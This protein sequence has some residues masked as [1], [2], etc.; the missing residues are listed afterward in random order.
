MKSALV[1]G[2]RGFIG[3]HVFDRLVADGW[4][5]S[6]CDVKDG[7]S[8]DC[9]LVFQQPYEFDLVIHCAAVVG[10]RATIDGQPMKVA[11]DLAI[12]SDFFQYILRTKP[13][14][15]IYFSSSAAY[16]V[17]YQKFVRRLEEADIVP[18]V[19]QLPDAIYGWVKLTGEQ[20]AV[21]AAAEGASI[22]VFR[23]FSG[24][25]EDQDLDY[26]FP[27][28][29][30]RAIERQDPFPVWGTGEQVRDWIHVDDIV[31]AVI[32]SLDYD[33]ADLG[34]LNLATGRG[35]SMNSLIRAA[36]AVVGYTPHLDPHPQAPT[37]V[38]YR[39]GDPTLMNQRLYTPQVSLTE[40][41]LRA[42]KAMS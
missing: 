20:L 31:E 23:P 19:P 14:R 8:G 35:T 40:G 9:R 17:H 29:I 38:H 26:P 13:R 1:T 16:P 28:F 30:K 42:V 32:R 18:S 6:G 11:T 33:P 12:D 21:H 41:V 15:A 7:P 5:T 24:Y 4:V 37:G 34:T 27:T 25:G 36:A 39:V 3:R 22:Q 10:G 2:H